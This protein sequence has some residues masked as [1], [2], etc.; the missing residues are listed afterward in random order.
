MFFCLW[1]GVFSAL[2]AGEPS[3]GSE[4][5]VKIGYVDLQRVLATVAEA[6]KARADLEREFK[7]KKQQLDEEQVRLK[8]MGDDFMQQQTA[9]SEEAKV[10]RQTE[11]RERFEKLNESMSK[12]Q[13][14]LQTKEQEMSRPII[15]KIREIVS[16]IAKRKAYSTVLEKNDMLVLYSWEKDDLTPEVMS[17]FDERYPVK[18]AKP[19]KK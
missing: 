8:K 3:K 18:E 11:L 1:F 17:T 19:K 9:M 4:D 6:K 16:D 7:A 14:D 2:A 10:K 15:G 13:T 12:A 5:R